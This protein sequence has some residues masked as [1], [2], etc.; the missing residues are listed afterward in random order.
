MDTL[1]EIRISPPI[2]RTFAP[3]G[4]QVGGDYERAQ[5]FARTAPPDESN[6]WRL[7]RQARRAEHGCAEH[8]LVRYQHRLAASAFLARSLVRSTAQLEEWSSNQ[9]RVG[10]PVPFGTTTQTIPCT[11]HHWV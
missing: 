2:P 9:R 6:R 11:L 4:Y 10:G 7:G 1:V 8:F 5:A 3:C